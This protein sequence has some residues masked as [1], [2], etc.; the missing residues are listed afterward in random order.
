MAHTVAAGSFWR[1]IVC[2]VR[3]IP[4]PCQTCDRDDLDPQLRFQLSLNGS[5]PFVPFSQNNPDLEEWE[6]KNISIWGTFP[7]YF[8]VRQFTNA[9]LLQNLHLIISSHFK[10]S[11]RIKL[12]F[13]QIDTICTFHSFAIAWFSLNPL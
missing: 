12:V 9:Y 10:H 5:T 13:I 2:Q 7:H 4:P 11:G 6:L 1:P 3:K 8:F